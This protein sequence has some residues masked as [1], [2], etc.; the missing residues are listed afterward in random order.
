MGMLS[1]GTP[2]DMAKR[3]VSAEKKLDRIIEL[4][5]LNAGI[6]LHQEGMSPDDIA[7]IILG[8]KTLR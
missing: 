6:M 2:A 4:L 5:E 7:K 1:I 8:K 3:A